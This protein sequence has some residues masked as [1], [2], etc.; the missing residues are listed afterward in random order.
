MEISYC[1]PVT[2][3][4]P[5][6][7][8][9]SFLRETIDSV[10]CQTYYDFELLL[11]DDGSTDSSIDIIKSY[12]DSRI[13]YISCSHDFVGTL[14]KGLDIAKGK[15]LALLDHDDLMMPHRLQMQYNY[16]ES[17]L[18]IIACGGYMHSFGW[19]S[20][21]IKAPLEYNELINEMIIRSPM[22]NPTGFIRRDA[23]VSHNIRYQKGYSFAA[24]FK[25][26][27]DLVKVGKVVNIPKILTLYRTYNQQ[28]SIVFRK[29]SSVGAHSIQLEIVEYL[30]SLVDKKS[31]IYDTL[32][33]KLIPA[34]DDLGE[35]SFFSE[36]VFFSFMY[37]VIK[38]IHKEEAIML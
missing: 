18:N 20:K 21:E 15:Y 38:G 3:M 36:K 33:E 1:V 10:L 8:A 32:N 7:N 16:L 24:D 11:L 2:V 37:E 4:I 27:A 17:N 23:I 29:E 26:W 9:E 25:F 28:T 13:C 31:R 14:N 30:L 22:L 19:Y 5:V 6:Y 35:L 34:L 12:K